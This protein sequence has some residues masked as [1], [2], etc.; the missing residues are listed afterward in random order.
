[1]REHTIVLLMMI[2]GLST[3]ACSTRELFANELRAVFK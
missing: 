1:M 3:V 2:S